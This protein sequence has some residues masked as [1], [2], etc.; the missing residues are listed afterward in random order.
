[1]AITEDASSPAV[2]TTT[3][4]ANPT[5][6]SF[7]PPANTLVVLMVGGGWSSSASVLSVAI[8]NTGTALTWQEGAIAVG[9]T[10]G[11][12]GGMAK[13]FYAWTGGTAPGAITVT[14][15]F[16]NLS[17]GTQ[18]TTKVLNGAA[19]VQFGASIGNARSTTNASTTATVVVARS[20]AG[21]LIYGIVDDNAT[22]GTLT[23]HDSNTTI[24][25]AFQDVTDN[26]S[27]ASFKST[28][29]TTALGNGTFGVTISVANSNNIVA[30]EI[31]PTGGIVPARNWS[32]NPG[33]GTDLAGWARDA[34]NSVARVAQSG[35]NRANCCRLTVAGTPPA[36]S[37]LRTPQLPA[38][39]G[40]TWVVSVQY[41]CS[42]SRAG[43]AFLNFRDSFNSFLS[44][45]PS[46][47]ITAST[48]VQ[49][50]TFTVVTAPVLTFAID[51]DFEFTTFA[52]ADTFDM[53]CALFQIAPVAGAYVDGDSAGWVWDGTAEDSTSRSL[54]VPSPPLRILQ[55]VNQSNY[56]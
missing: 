51:V 43:T 23:A 30:M 8:T 4:A 34:T 33:C 9:P 16:T 48:T 56:F 50:A 54:W 12:T 14:A 37:T 52:A 28:N 7:S 11:S 24:I 53:T 40:Q 25:S 41:R 38:G 15:T 2:V 36:T 6:A 13:M 47:A 17:G 21:S 35:F 55:A 18:L 20:V 39:A 10:G 42:T 49:T 27:I 3:G 44:P 31:I 19:A 26:I 1:M 32:T 22:N 46:L 29:A 45:N 5:T